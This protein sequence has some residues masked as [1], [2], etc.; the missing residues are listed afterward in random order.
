MLLFEY[1]LSLKVS[2]LLVGAGRKPRKCAVLLPF[3]RKRHPQTQLPLLLQWR[4][5]CRGG[6][7]SE[8]Y[9]SGLIGVK[10]LTRRIIPIEPSRLNLGIKCNVIG[11]CVLCLPAFNGTQIHWQR[12]YWRRVRQLRWLGAIFLVWSNYGHSSQTNWMDWVAGW[13]HWA[14]LVIL[15]VGHRTRMQSW[16]H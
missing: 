12:R 15:E 11:G 9:L 1:F 6:A 8:G 16:V 10:T 14:W 4:R 3:L 13:D 5:R 7:W 2:F